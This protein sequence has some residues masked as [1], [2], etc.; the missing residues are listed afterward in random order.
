MLLRSMPPS[1]D[2]LGRPSS[3]PK[4]PRLERLAPK[5]RGHVRDEGL[6]R[7]PAP[8]SG[9]CPTGMRCHNRK[10][11]KSTPA[12]PELPPECCRMRGGEL[13]LGC[14]LRSQQ[15]A[16]VSMQRCKRRVVTRTLAPTTCRDAHTADNMARP[17]AG[18]KWLR[19]CR[20]SSAC[21]RSPCQ[22]RPSE[23]QRVEGH[24][25]G[26]QGAVP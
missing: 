1:R 6:R 22:N 4:R 13:R 7:S 26:L 10:R 23:R 3:R 17:A 12:D 21:Q 19:G 20:V 2:T 15:G 14:D 5:V 16:W 8:P 24:L 9:T 25:K 18:V 11:Q